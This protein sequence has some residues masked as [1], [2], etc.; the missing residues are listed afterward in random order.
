[1]KKFEVTPELDRI[2]QQA[3]DEDIVLTR[4]GHPVALLSDFDDEDL[5]WY[6]REHDPDFLASLVR[7][8]EQVKKGQVLG[9]DELKK[10][11]GIE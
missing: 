6:A 1:M 7:A 8:R 2:L 4:D 9:H 3:K 11:L 5:Y 10:R